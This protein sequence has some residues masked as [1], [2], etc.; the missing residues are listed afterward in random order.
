MI[1]GYWQQYMLPLAFQMETYLIDAKMILIE[2]IIIL[3]QS[4]PKTN[5]NQLVCQRICW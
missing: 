4:F 2:M 5:K 1:E 3:E